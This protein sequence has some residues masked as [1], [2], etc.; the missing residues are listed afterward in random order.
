MLILISPRSKSKKVCHRRWNTKTKRKKILRMA[1]ETR[2]KIRY[3]FLHNLLMRLFC[4]VDL[5]LLLIYFHIVS[6]ASTHFA[7]GSFFFFAHTDQKPFLCEPF[8]LPFAVKLFK[9]FISSLTLAH[10]SLH[11]FCIMFCGLIRSLF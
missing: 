2:K 3:I 9:V 7:V 10:H 8:N 11:L 5:F 4:C 1:T 6:L